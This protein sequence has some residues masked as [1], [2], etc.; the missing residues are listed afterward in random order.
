MACQQKQVVDTKVNNLITVDSEWSETDFQTPP[1]ESKV[2]VWYHWINGHLSKEEITKDMEAMK[3]VGIGGF[4]NFNVGE[5]TPP[6]NA[7]YGSRDR[8][9]PRRRAALAGGAAFVGHY[10]GELL[11]VDLKTGK[12]LWKYGAG[13]Q[14]FFAS[15]AVGAKRVVVGGRDKRVHCINRKTGKTLWKFR[16][17]DNVD[18]SPVICGDKVLAASEDGRLYILSLAKGKLLWSYRIGE[19][20]TACPAVAGGKF[21]IGCQDGYIYAFG[22]KTTK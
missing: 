21:I 20:I 4:T 15:P 3:E 8:P 22:Q 18:S 13:E 10:D 1:D 6:G 7:P 16:T 17:K 5:G 9:R 12:T 11:K 2:K 19:A 14:P